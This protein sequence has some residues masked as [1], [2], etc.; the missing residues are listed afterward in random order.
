M[1]SI[2]RVGLWIIVLCN[3]PGRALVAQGILPH[4]SAAQCNRWAASLSGDTGPAM[5][6]LTY[7]AIMRCPLVAPAALASAIRGARAVNDTAFLGRLAGAAGQ[8]RHPAV[9]DAGL[10]VAAD[11]RAVTRARIMGLLVTVAQLGNAQ[12]IQGYTRAGLFTEILPAHGICAFGVAAG[13]LEVAYPLPEDAER[14]AARVI[15]G[16]RF[17]PGTPARLA[18]LSRC[19]RANLDP[20]I[21]PYI[22]TSR[23]R[24]DHVCD[25]T[26][27]VQNHTGAQLTLSYVLIDAAGE[28]MEEAD[29]VASAAGGWTHFTVMAPGTLRISH[30][31]RVVATAVA[32]PVRC[33]V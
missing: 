33:E 30:D 2:L 18:R 13:E 15:D 7:G 3:V 16:L 28:V 6:V 32:G 4:P 19:A 17:R 29:V 1:K 22:D 26:F 27:R 5:E 23:I 21:P 24:L 31:G 9:F 10:E 14:R 11:T 12:D 8:V 20:Q 25:A